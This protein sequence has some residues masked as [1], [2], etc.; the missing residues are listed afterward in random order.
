MFVRVKSTPNSPRKSIQIVEN[1]RVG[2]TT[3]QKILHYVGVAKD[4]I[5]AEQLKNLAHETI[6]RLEKE[7]QTQTEL[8][9]DLE[10]KTRGRKPQK[11]ISD[12]IPT[13]EVSLDDIEEE[14]RIV[15]GVD[16]IAGSAYNEIGYDKLLTRGASQ[17]LKDVV[18]ARLIFPYSKHKLCK[19]LF[20]QFDKKYDLNK[21]YRLMDQIHPNINKIKQITCAKTQALMPN[22]DVVLFDVTTLHFESIDADEFREFGYSKNF[23]FNTTQ[24]VLALATNEHGLPIGYELFQGNKAEVKTL[25]ESINKWRELFNINNVTFVGD[26]AMFSK[27]NLA[28]MDEYGYKYVIAAKLRG[29]SKHLQDQILDEKN[30]QLDFYEKDV[31]WIGEFN[32]D[33]DHNGRKLISTYAPSRARHDRNHR[34]QILESLQPK[35][36]AA[37]KLIKNG[38]K[39]YIKVEAGTTAIDDAKIVRD[40]QWDGMHGIITNIHD[41]HA[42]E[43]LTKYRSLWHIEEAFRINKHDLKMRPIYHWTQKRIESHVALCYMSFALL[44]YIQ[45]KVEVTQIKFSVQ[46]VLEVLMKVQ[47][48]IHVHKKTGDRYRLPSSMSNNARCIYKAFEVERSLDASIYLP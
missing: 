40:E 31:S 13:S 15:E 7:R 18:L 12:I 27:D 28:L 29:L 11:D 26:R 39:K 10:P 44:K 5:M 47:A 22:A 21:L 6:K 16:E 38:A 3:K 20:E 32:L 30:Y 19:T 14:K 8:F 1:V 43:L 41:K 33:G 9:D 23:R 34:N 46:D 4:E 42:K 25:I 17:L 37:V 45:Y 36:G 35:T 2:N 24:V 48:S